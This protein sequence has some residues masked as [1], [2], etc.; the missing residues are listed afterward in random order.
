MKSLFANSTLFFAS[1]A[2]FTAGIAAQTNFYADPAAPTS[3]SMMIECQTAS[4]PTIPPIDDDET[5]GTKV[6][7]G[8]TIPPIDDD[9]T[10][11]TKVAS[12]P[13]IP[14]IDDDETGGTKVV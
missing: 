13:T 10:G 3:L 6:A 1:A 9:E 12:G 11:G 5:G 8:P 2:L 7:S 4:G 14:P